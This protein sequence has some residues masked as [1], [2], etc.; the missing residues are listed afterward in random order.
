MNRKNDISDEILN[1][2][3]DNQ[4]TLDDKEELYSRIS[5]DSALNRQ[6][7]EIRKVRDL[8]QTAY[9]DV[10]MPPAG[11]NP[12]EKSR[13]GNGWRNIAAGAVLALGVVIGWQVNSFEPNEKISLASAGKQADKIK[14]L[15]H[16]NSDKAETVSEALTEVENLLKHYTKTNQNA[17]VE[18]VTNGNGL[19]LLRRDTSTHVNQIKALQQKYPNLVFVACQNTIDRLKKEQGI[20]AQLVEG[21]MVIDSGVAQIMRRQQQGWAYIQV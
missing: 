9:R 14:V 13:N 11:R 1:A 20:S 15:F 10:P 18:F 2:F 5:E 21:V 4:M 17:V 8:V 6:V 3:V 19:S 12:S 7:C 16:L